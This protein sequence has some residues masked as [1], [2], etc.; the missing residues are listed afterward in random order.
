[1]VS[2]NA[3]AFAGLM[4][5][6][7][8]LPSAA[9]DSPL[10]PPEPTWAHVEP[11]LR[12]HCNHCHGATAER[13]GSA[14]G[15]V[16]RFDFY[17][18]EADRCGEAASAISGTT[19]APSGLAKAWA[20]LIKSSVTTK[21][22][23]RPRMPPAPASALAD[24]E[25]ETLVRWADLQAPR[26]MP[27]S[28]NRPP[29]I[30]LDTRQADREITVHATVTDPDG[31]S[32]VGVL[33][34]GPQVLNMDRAGS[35]AATVD[36]K[37][38]A[39]GKYPVSAVLCDG[40]AM[41]QQTLGEVQIGTPLPTPDAAAPDAATPDAGATP[42]AAGPDTGPVDAGVDAP[43]R[44]PDLDHNGKLDCDENLLVNAGFD[45]DLRGW[46]QETNTAQSFVARD[47]QHRAGSG[48]IAITNAIIEDDPG[49]TLA[50]SG[51]CLDAKAQARYL[52]RAQVLVAAGQPGSDPARAAGVNIR[53]WNAPGCA[54]DFVGAAVFPLAPELPVEVWRTVS[55]Q[56]TAPAAA[57]SMTVRLVAAKSFKQPPFRVL[58]DNPLVRI[59]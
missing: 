12:A 21:D 4:I 26:G 15:V 56:A 57:R 43:L 1:M 36:A 29:Q 2:I 37:A 47:G 46:T 49:A 55:G 17:D 25:R 20:S 52:I 58:V 30:K 39:D 45:Q 27:R 33:K 24:W 3:R 51:Q 19:S 16:Y 14:S 40:W 34:L 35:F 10:P 53:F 28:N 41:N 42:D 22:G 48:A 5:C 54:G 23:S 31:E 7:A 44:C 13:T 50:G 9:C 59:E 6:A 18:L 38:W 32:A 11:L 8:L